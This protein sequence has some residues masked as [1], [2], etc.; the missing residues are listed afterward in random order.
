MA[1]EWEDNPKKWMDLQL[2]VLQI[3]PCANDFSSYTVSKIA[4]TFLGAFFRDPQTVTVFFGEYL[5][6]PF[7]QTPPKHRRVKQ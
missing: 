1:Y 5:A 4:I 2:F 7:T 6:K 3:H